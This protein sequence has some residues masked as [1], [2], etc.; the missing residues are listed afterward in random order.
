[1]TV[2]LDLIKRI[3]YNR[4]TKD[5]DAFVT[6]DGRLEQY[7]GSAADHLAAEK[8]CDDYAFNYYADN[9]TPEKAAQIALALF[10]ERRASDPEPAPP[11]D[12]G[13]NDHAYLDALDG[14]APWPAARVNWSESPTARLI[15]C[16]ELHEL[17]R[18]NPDA[19]RARLAALDDAALEMQAG[20]YAIYASAQ[21]GQ[22]VTKDE[23]LAR[24]RR[25]IAVHRA[26]GELLGS[27]DAISHVIY[28]LVLTDIP[29]LVEF[30]RGHTAAQRDQLAWR[31]TAW[32]R[33]HHG[34]ARE[35]AHIAAGWASIVGAA[36][37][38]TGRAQAQ[39]GADEQGQAVEHD[40]ST[41]GTINADYTTKARR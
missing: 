41:N 32:L 10:D 14:K 22:D 28:E 38:E 2:H 18:A 39:P 27:E 26:R 5:Y 6:I 29:A 34:I 35:P 9:A 16:A 15:P 1:M 40:P 21:T 20:V 17:R 23:T 7:I 19:F 12:D 13:P 33:R 11:V 37:N 8:L 31:F 4:F 25:S 36:G 3:A 30:L 24:F